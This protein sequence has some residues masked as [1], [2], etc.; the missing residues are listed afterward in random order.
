MF[1]VNENKNYS[2][3]WGGNRIGSG[4]PKQETQSRSVIVSSM[5]TKEEKK[6]I[7]EMAQQTGQSES[8]IVRN[9]LIKCKIIKNS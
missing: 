8:D 5:I 6:Q 7:K 4:R 3:N 2:P 9:A 1:G